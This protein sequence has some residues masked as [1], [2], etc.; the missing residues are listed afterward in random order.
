M[1]NLTEFQQKVLD[2]V[3]Y[4]PGEIHIVRVI[5][6]VYGAWESRRKQ[7][8]RKSSVTK[9]LSKLREAGK[10]GCRQKVF[11]FRENYWYRNK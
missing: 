9:A 11:G 6:N 5:N 3:P 2:A 4:T 10:V 1:N 8:G 7:R